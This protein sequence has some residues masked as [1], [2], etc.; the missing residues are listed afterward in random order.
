[1]SFKKSVLSQGMKLMQDPRIMKV[2][3]DPRVMQVMAKGFELKGKVQQDFDTRVEK[4]ADS[5]NL[6]TKAEV[7]ELKRTIRKLERDL[8][9]KS[10]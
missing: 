6:A 1:M 3:Q 10:G 9:K 7:R 8:S 5:L 2:L 4:M